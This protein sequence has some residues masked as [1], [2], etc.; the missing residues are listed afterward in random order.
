MFRTQYSVRPRY[1]SNIG[2]PVKIL[3]SP[4][5]SDTG[6]IELVES[7]RENLYEYI[8]S[9]KDS[10]DI[11]VLFERF[12]KGD[13]SVL[14]RFSQKQGFFAD[15]TEIPKTYAGVLN[16]LLAVEDYFNKLPADIRSKFDNSLS[17][18]ISGIGS[19]DFADKLG[20]VSDQKTVEKSV[21]VK[22]DVLSE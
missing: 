1:Y 11:N 5:V 15:I 13:T 4:Q 3:Y 20:L 6:H 17:V 9:F 8:Q 12:Q 7:G 10:V 18:F 16:Q 14:E 19:S 21:E 2:D 22:G